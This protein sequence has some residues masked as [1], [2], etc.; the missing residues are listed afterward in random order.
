MM[1]PSMLPALVVLGTV[2]PPTQIGFLASHEA[3]Y[4]ANF[5]SLLAASHAAALPAA[6]DSQCRNTGVVLVSSTEVT[7]TAQQATA[8]A[9]QQACGSSST[10]IV[11]AG[12]MHEAHWMRT[13]RRAQTC[14]RRTPV[15]SD[16]RHGR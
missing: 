14:V 7:L 2:P 4:A 16:P 12:G 1:L 15:R 11:P 13:H 5:S 10:C 9:A 8:A 6:L 3:E